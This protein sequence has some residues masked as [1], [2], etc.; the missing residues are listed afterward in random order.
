MAPGLCVFV[1]SGSKSLTVPP[2][3]ARCDEEGGSRARAPALTAG[4]LLRRGLNAALAV[5]KT[6]RWPPREEVV[7]LPGLSGW[8]TISRR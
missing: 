4:K 2:S 7:V 3:E 1:T 5:A 8:P 6:G